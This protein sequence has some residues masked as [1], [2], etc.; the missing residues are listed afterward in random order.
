MT[1][2]PMALM[3]IS[4][5]AKTL[6]ALAVL[7]GLIVARV[8]VAVATTPSATPSA[9]TATAAPFF[10]VSGGGLFAGAGDALRLCA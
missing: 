6:S 10:F 5:L 4:V 9:A 7:R 3:R 1:L 2:M 8:A